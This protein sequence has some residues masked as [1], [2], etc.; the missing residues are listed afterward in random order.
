MV[1]K[2]FRGIGNR[3]EREADEFGFALVRRQP[4]D[5]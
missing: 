4:R 3:E 2:R 1:T 5:L